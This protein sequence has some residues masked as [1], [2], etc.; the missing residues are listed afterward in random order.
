[1]IGAL[2]VIPPSLE[3]AI[4]ICATVPP[5]DRGWCPAVQRSQETYTVP[6]GPVASVG[7]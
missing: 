1:M 2:H 3:R 5:H 4:S 6:S 7:N